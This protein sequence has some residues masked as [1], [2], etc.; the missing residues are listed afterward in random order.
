MKCKPDKRYCSRNEMGYYSY[1][2][3]LIPIRQALADG[4]Y[5]RACN[6]LYSLLY[7]D[8]FLQKRIKHNVLK[9]IEEFLESEIENCKKSVK[10]KSG[11]CEV[12]KNG[13][14]DTSDTESLLKSI[15]AQWLHTPIVTDL[16]KNAGNFPDGVYIGRAETDSPV[17]IIDYIKDDQKYMP[18]G[19]L[20]EG[21]S[22]RIIKD[23]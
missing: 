21:R 13:L 1:L 18:I 15:T 23:E 11:F 5:Q 2:I 12:G 4:L 8:Y 10:H 3:Y 22:V 20:R 7:H 6:E 19:A 9:V 14:D 17:I 16:C